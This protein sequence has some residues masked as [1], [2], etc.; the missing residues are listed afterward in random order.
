MAEILM[1]FMKKENQLFLMGKFILVVLVKEE[2]QVPQ[3]AKFI[4]KGR[5]L[6][7]LLLV[8]PI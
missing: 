6:S 4:L 3:M 5:L 8:N 2:D 7:Q 1:V